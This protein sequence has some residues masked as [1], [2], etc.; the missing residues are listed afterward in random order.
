MVDGRIAKERTERDVACG[1]GA[2]KRGPVCVGRTAPPFAIP[3]PSGPSLVLRSPS[4]PRHYIP[5]S[6]SLCTRIPE[7]ALLSRSRI[8]T[9]TDVYTYTYMYFFMYNIYVHFPLFLPICVSSSRSLFL[10][11][12]PSSPFSLYLG[13]SFISLESFAFF[14]IFALLHMPHRPISHNNSNY[15]TYTTMWRRCTR[16]LARVSVHVWRTC[17]SSSRSG[18]ESAFQFYYPPQHDLDNEILRGVFRP[19]S[20]LHSTIIEIRMERISR[21]AAMQSMIEKR[22]RSL[23]ARKVSEGD[24]LL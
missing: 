7:E 9:Y 20:E 10:S 14:R 4:A 15:D 18:R 13:L 16:S 17:S 8:Q 21:A 22:G 12:H 2:L 3:G 19:P 24:Q 11:L 5:P 23:W 6:F 1:P